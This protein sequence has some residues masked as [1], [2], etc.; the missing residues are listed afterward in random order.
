MIKF[1]AFEPMRQV[2]TG[3]FI[4]LKSVKPYIVEPTFSD[5]YL[6]YKKLSWLRHV[7]I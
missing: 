3:N 1:S 4:Y 7:S 2:V 5:I 6:L